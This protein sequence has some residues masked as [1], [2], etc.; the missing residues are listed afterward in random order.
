MSSQKKIG[1]DQVPAIPEGYHMENHT[2]ITSQHEIEVDRVKLTERKE[3]TKVTDNDQVNLGKTVVKHIRSIKEP[4]G[5]G[6]EE[7]TSPSSMLC[8]QKERHS[9]ESTHDSQY[10]LEKGGIESSESRGGPLTDHVS[11]TSSFLEPVGYVTQT[12]TIYQRMILKDN[13]EEVEGDRSVETNLDDSEVTKFLEKWNNL[14]QPKVSDDQV[15]NMI[16][17]Y[18]EQEE[19]GPSQ[20]LCWGKERNSQDSKDGSQPGSKQTDEKGG[21]HGV[22]SDP[23]LETVQVGEMKVSTVES[24]QID[25]DKKEDYTHTGDTIMQKS[26]KEAGR[27]EHFL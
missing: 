13:G 23:N 25:V 21:E 3:T 17:G 27:P 9:Q 11:E 15:Q 24:K 18:E 26:V 14:W 2:T 16:N 22:T 6:K 4:M 12:I 7:E 19:A 8:C 10:S 1:S 5:M 20:I